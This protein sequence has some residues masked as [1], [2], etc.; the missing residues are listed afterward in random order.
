[1]QPSHLK[2]L[3]AIELALRLGSLTK[4]AEALSIT[5]AAVGQRIK[6]I[7]DYLD[8]E[9]VVR[10]RSGLQP[11][12]ALADALE[13]L[14][15]AF[16]ELE[17]FGDLLDVQKG[18]EIHIAAP[19]DFAELWLAPRLPHFRQAHPRV[20]F[21]VNGE[22]DAPYRVGRL[23]C[24]IT[25]GPVQ[26]DGGWKVLFQDFLVP[27]G[28][29]EN[30]RRIQNLAAI[31]RL[32]GFPLLHLDLYKNDPAAIGWAEWIAAAKLQR[33]APNRGIRF[34]RVSHGL[35]AVMSHAG[36]MVCG[37]ALVSHLVDEHQL[38]L[39]Y[40][41][42]TGAWTSHAYQVR[43]GNLP[44]RPQVDR[45]HRWLMDECGKTLGWLEMQAA[46]TSEQ[47]TAGSALSAPHPS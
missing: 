29:P 23:D 2:S 33:S 9:L 39:P 38:A 16:R 20:L 31:E 18:E 5:P 40:P 45:F 44:A 7:E 10:G 36:L 47:S 13:H 32:E 17:R 12:A 22:G 41:A 4:A 46:Q 42:E 3:Q 37:L 34:N 26:A 27:V 8:L 6:V 43:S 1:M 28:S 21:C 35:S 14:H 24:L 19:S 25:F 30:A 11:T 15:I